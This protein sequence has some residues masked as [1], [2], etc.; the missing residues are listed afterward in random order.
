LDILSFRISGS[1]AAFRD[2]SVTSHQTVSFI[3]SKSAVIGIIG[4]MIGVKRSNSLAEL[5]SQEYL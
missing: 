3:P 1:F 5:Y 4:A 2:P